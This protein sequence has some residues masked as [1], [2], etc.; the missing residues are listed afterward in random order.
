MFK[1]KLCFVNSFTPTLLTAFNN[2]L[3]IDN[4]MKNLKVD[5][6]IQKKF[7]FQDS[8]ELYSSSFNAF[9]KADNLQL[10]AG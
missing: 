2:N 4:L 5:S 7:N 6:K 10:Y 9:K 8:T 1:G 3:Q